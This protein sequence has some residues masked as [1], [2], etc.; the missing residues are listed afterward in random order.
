MCDKYGIEGYPTIKMLKNEQIID[1]D[2]KPTI[3]NLTKFVETA[4]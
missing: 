2:A 4:I 1:F 3:E